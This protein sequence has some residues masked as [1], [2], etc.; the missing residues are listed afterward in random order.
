[1][2]KFEPDKNDI[3]ACTLLMRALGLVDATISQFWF[4]P[5]KQCLDEFTLPEIN[6]SVCG[7]KMNFWDYHLSQGWCETCIEKQSKKME[8]E[9]GR[10]K[11]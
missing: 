7:T 5:I 3:E 9:K 2:S 11:G 1:M 10:V 8:E 4:D 6:C